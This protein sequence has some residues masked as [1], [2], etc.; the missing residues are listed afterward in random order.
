MTREGL[1]LI[2]MPQDLVLKHNCPR[3]IYGVR[4]AENAFEY[5]RGEV[6][7][8]TYVFSRE[9]ARGEPSESSITGSRGGSSRGRAR[10]EPRK[11]RGA[12]VRGPA[13]EP[14]RLC[15]DA[16][17]RAQKQEARMS[18][19]VDFLS[20]PVQ[21]AFLLR[22]PA[23]PEQFEAIHVP[24]ALEE[25]VRKWLL[26]KKDVVLLGNP[27]DGK[28]HLFRGSMMCSS[29]SRPT[30]CSTL[31]PKRTTDGSCA[32]WKAASD[33][34][35]PSAWR[36]IKGR[37]ISCCWSKSHRVPQLRGTRRPTRT[38]L[39]YDECPRRQ[40]RSSRGP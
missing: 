9:T 29:A 5:L 17:R 1:G 33:A 4:L 40:R 21:Q 14:G 20:G 8:P 15:R 39:Y 7:E 27:G 34:R 24:T 31:P 23:E 22:R 26:A 2:G 10:G 38:L 28:T 19:S 11:G 16:P 36:S 13:A 37:S 12:S 3:L 6:D 35:R 25:A 32:R 30:S 18:V